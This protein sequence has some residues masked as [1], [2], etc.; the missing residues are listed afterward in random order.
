[1]MEELSVLFAAHYL[2]QL[3]DRE[4]IATLKK[5]V[6][7]TSNTSE[8]TIDSRFISKGGELIIECSER[9]KKSS[10]DEIDIDNS[11]EDLR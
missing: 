6:S 4:M 5:E 8:G 1:M 2:R 10:E 11:E 7:Q 9:T 3:R